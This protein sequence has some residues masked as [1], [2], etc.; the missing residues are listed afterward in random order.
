LQDGKVN[1][2]RDF[3]EP[4]NSDVDLLHWPSP[5]RL[6]HFQPTHSFLRPA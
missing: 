1:D 5:H 4:D 2:L 6:C 3:T